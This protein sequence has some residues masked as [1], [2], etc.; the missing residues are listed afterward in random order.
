MYLT[1]LFYKY[2]H[3]MYT[4]CTCTVYDLHLQRTVQYLE[5]K[6]IR[7]SREYN[8][9]GKLALDLRRELRELLEC[10]APIDELLVAHEHR[11]AGAAKGHHVELV[12]WLIPLVLHN[13]V[14]VG[15]LLTL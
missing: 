9:I 14:E 4:Y 15:G 13:L 11:E 2:N 6:T 3:G 10:A 7:K 8:C 12:H 1:K 5:N